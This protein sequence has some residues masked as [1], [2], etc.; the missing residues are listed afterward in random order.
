MTDLLDGLY[1][2]FSDFA[3]WVVD[4]VLDGALTL[5]EAIPAPDFFTNLQGYANAIDGSVLFWVAPLNIS[6]GLG[7]IMS[8]YIIKFIL[9]RIPFIGG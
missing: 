5:L 4:L 2:L 7:I 1:D 9:K 3:L 8:A 6:T